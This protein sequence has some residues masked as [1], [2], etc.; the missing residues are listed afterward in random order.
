MLL[1]W[2]A[3]RNMFSGICVI[4]LK[5]ITSFK[6]HND[7][8]VFFFFCMKSAR[9]LVHCTPLV[10]FSHKKNS[11]GFQLHF[12]V[13]NVYI[14]VF[15]CFSTS[16]VKFQPFQ[17]RDEKTSQTCRVTVLTLSF[18]CVSCFV[19]FFLIVYI[20]GKNLRCAGQA[21]KGK[22]W[23]QIVFLFHGLL[24]LP[25]FFFKGKR[26]LFWILVSEKII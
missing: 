4:K 15:C 6:G 8:S 16:R 17:R 3:N 5:I 20:L 13:L 23:I 25:V 22:Q 24:C 21:L 18:Q 2:E 14:F 11:F 12:Q 1:F 26:S 9:N 7:V 19:V 10:S